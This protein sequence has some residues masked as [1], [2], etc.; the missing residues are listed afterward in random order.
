LGFE[1]VDLPLELRTLRSQ[2]DQLLLDDLTPPC[3]SLREPLRELA[4]H[5][6]D[7]IRASLDRTDRIRD[8]RMIG[9]GERAAHLELFAL[10]RIELFRKALTLVLR[11]RFRR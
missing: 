3:F 7:R 11:D 8:L 5:T 4:L 2:T 6:G 9:R 1:L 10:E